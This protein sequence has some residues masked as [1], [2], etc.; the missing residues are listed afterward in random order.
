MQ[1]HHNDDG[2]AETRSPAKDCKSRAQPIGALAAFPACAVSY[3]LERRHPCLRFA[4]I[5]PELTLAYARA[6]DTPLATA[7]GSVLF[8]DPAA[9]TVGQSPHS[10]SHY[11]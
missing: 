8:P 1:L 7:S 9:S 11:H 4:G 3:D 6:S 10:A 2:L 5:L